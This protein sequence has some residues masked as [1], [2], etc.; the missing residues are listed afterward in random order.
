MSEQVQLDNLEKLINLLEGY[1]GDCTL[2]SLPADVN[3]SISNLIF[4]A[5]LPSPLPSTVGGLL[6]E[7]MALKKKLTR[8]SEAVP[9]EAT[10]PGTEVA[11]PLKSKVLGMRA[12]VS[13]QSDDAAQK[14][15]TPGAS[16]LR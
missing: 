7:V 3:L 12:K 1:G 2:D 4:G 15:P 16:R 10:T 5:R 9:P 13:P 6:A 14:R 8:E 11:S